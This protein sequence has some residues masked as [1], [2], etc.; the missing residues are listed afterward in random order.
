MRAALPGANPGKGRRV[1]S[2]PLGHT[3][4]SK[5][6]TQNSKNYAAL[7]ETTLGNRRPRRG[8]DLAFYQLR[9]P[10][11]QEGYCRKSTGSDF[12][13][14]L[15]SGAEPSGDAKPEVPL[16]WSRIGLRELNPFR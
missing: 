14:E 5:P 4:N 16:G 10:K 1:N 7:F 9:V 2:I 11:N 8:R 3:Q 6:E 12:H 15:Q 13:H